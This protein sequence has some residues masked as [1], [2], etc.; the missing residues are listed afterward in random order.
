MA[1]HMLTTVDNPFSPFTQFDEWRN[2]DEA[3][4]YFTLEFLGRVVI[5][6]D[7]LSEADQDAAI[8][9]AIDEICSENVL[10]IYKKIEVVEVPEPAASSTALE[11]T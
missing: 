5:I 6:S 2:Y 9:S 3:A 7:D 11:P 4:G 1:L 10:G 8:E